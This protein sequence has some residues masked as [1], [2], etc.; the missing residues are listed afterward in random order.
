LQPILRELDS[1]YFPIVPNMS[2][3]LSGRG[4]GQMISVPTKMLFPGEIVRFRPT[5]RIATKLVEPSRNRCRAPF[6]HC[7]LNKEAVTDAVLILH[8][9]KATIDLLAESASKRSCAMAVRG[10]LR[11][12]GSLWGCR[13]WG[14]TRLRHDDRIFVQV[15]QIEQCVLTYERNSPERNHPESHTGISRKS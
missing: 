4:G 6:R 8:Q 15:N 11:Q 7:S 14:K 5:A 10:H 13:R 1:P 2:M 9:R 3:R 12:V